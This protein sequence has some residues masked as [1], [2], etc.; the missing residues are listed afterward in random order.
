MT[1]GPR[2][3]DARVR[4]EMKKILKEIQDGSFAKEW[5][6]ENKNGR[7][8]F[9]KMKERDANHQIEIVGKKLRGMMS[10]LKKK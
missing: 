9:N 2:V 4:E 3:V 8:N 5:M 10:W 6:D 1:R 7:P